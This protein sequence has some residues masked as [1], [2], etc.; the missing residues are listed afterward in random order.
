M[1][2]NL[3]AEKFSANKEFE[4]LLKKNS[5]HVQKYYRLYFDYDNENVDVP[6]EENEKEVAENDP[7]PE[8]SRY[9]E[10]DDE[11]DFNLC[12]FL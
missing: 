4:E 5:E 12:S 1:E 11:Y 9:D 2:T 8:H 10:Q 7:D 3:D 6:G